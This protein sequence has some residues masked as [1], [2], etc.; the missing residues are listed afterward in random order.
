MASAPSVV[1]LT[2][3]E[4]PSEFENVFC[5]RNQSPKQ[6]AAAEKVLVAGADRRQRIETAHNIDHYD[7]IHKHRT[8]ASIYGDGS[9]FFVWSSMGHPSR[10]RPQ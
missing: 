5:P 2:T 4:F 9:D 6:N 1:H 8:S 3:K 10:E 7:R